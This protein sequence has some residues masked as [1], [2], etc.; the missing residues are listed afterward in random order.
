M[1][2][3]QLL[4]GVLLALV[5]IGA[6]VIY[7]LVTFISQSWNSFN[8]ESGSLA[9]RVVLELLMELLAT[10]IFITVGWITRNASRD[11]S[12]GSGYSEATSKLNK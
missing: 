1:Q 7:S 2:S 4:F 5:F 8:F 10:L 9:V 11:A 6:R 3:L 12:N